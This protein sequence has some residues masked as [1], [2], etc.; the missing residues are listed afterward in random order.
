MRIV[1]ML[2]SL[3]MGGAEKQVL[4]IAGRM[5][6][7]GHSVTIVTLLP[8]AK[9]E[10]PTSLPVVRLNLRKNPFSVPSMF[11][12]ARTAL[13]EL[14]P[15]IVHSHSFHANM[16][17]RVIA[18]VAGRPVVISTIHNVYEGGWP[19]MLAYRLTDNL[20]IHTTAVSKAAAERFVRLKAVR[21]EK[22]SAVPNA[23][24]LG[25]FAPDLSQ[26]SRLRASLNAGGDFVWLAAGRITAAKDYPNLLRA[27]VRVVEKTPMTKLWIAG[28]G[29]DSAMLRLGA[30]IGYLGLSGRVECLG[31]RRDLP[32]LLDAA[33][34]FVLGSAWEGMPLVIA[35]AMAKQKP[36]VATDVG[37]VG[38]LAG[39]AGT[40]VAAKNDAALAEAML[41][42]MR[43]P[44]ADRAALGRA[45]RA[46]IETSFNLDSRID[47]WESMYQSLAASPSQTHQG[48]Q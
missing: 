10:W 6:A 39:D 12:R 38:E 33:D 1:Y 30:L 18:P 13:R 17:A 45:A 14:K 25:E 2:A 29:T 27:M 19:R 36:V 7:R 3:G 31:L 11:F 5:A 16:V 22:C 9:Q 35:E 40:V 44:D 26:R 47:E 37:G 4:A 20:A 43:I 15:E 8:E 24:D 34:A 23:I 21:G 28:E 41:G 48:R 42:V 46:R 32:A